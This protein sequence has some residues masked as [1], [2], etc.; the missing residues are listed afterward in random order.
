MQVKTT[1]R[2][3]FI[4]NACFKEM[5]KERKCENA[6]EDIYHME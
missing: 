3:S 5:G 2:E 6:G 4:P 1:G